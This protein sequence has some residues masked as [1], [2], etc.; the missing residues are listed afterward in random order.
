MY[1]RVAAGREGR[2]ATI[3]TS[4][5][6][7]LFIA[8]WHCTRNEG[9]MHKAHFGKRISNTVKGSDKPV[10]SD[11]FRDFLQSVQIFSIYVCVCVYIYIYI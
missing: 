9:R 11:G 10:L 3:D 1:V 8:G 5:V 7:G 2:G 4:E 6:S